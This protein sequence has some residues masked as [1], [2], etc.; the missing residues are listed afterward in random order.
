MK[1]YRHWIKC[2]RDIPL[3][4]TNGRTLPMSVYGH[5]N[6][7]P[8]DARASGQRLLD[9]L[10]QRATGRPAPWEYDADG[11][12]I[13]EETLLELSP[14]NVVTRNRYGAEVLNSTQ[15]VFID[16]DG[17][18]PSGKGFFGWLGGLFSAR[19]PKDSDAEALARVARLAGKAGHARTHIRVYRTKAGYRLMLLDCD[20]EGKDSGGLMKA[21]HADPNYARLC[22]VQNCYRARLTPKPYR[23]RQR[24]IRFNFPE[25][26]AEVLEKQHQWLAEYNEKITTFATCRYIGSLNGPNGIAVNDAARYHDERTN[27]MTNLPLA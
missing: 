5:S 15:L 17:A 23:I 19:S 21:F 22:R 20:I 3:P 4:G 18:L 11:R 2:T 27:A 26:D 14:R 12:P 13:R 8:E 7:S 24:K 9:T 10:V 6:V 25:T 16:V 1:F